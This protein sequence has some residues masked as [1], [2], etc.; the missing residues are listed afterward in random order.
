MLIALHGNECM[1]KFDERLIIIT[2]LVTV[3]C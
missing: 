2:L 1:V 3:I